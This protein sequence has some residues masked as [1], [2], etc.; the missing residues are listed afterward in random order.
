MSKR[1]VATAAVALLAIAAAG[2]GG[3]S[4]ASSS[5]APATTT[6]AASQAKQLKVGLSL[7]LG[8]LNDRGFNHLS[9]VGLTRAERELGIEGRIHEA[10]S[11]QDYIPNMTS[12]ARQGF[13]LIIAIG[14]DQANAIAA[15]AKK[16]PQTHF[17]IVDVDWSTLPGKPKNVRGLLFREQQVGYLAG[18][19]AGLVVK[20]GIGYA[21]KVPVVSTVGG[22]KQPPVDRYIAGYQ[23][24]ARAAYPGIK[25]LNGYSQDWVAQDKCKE[26]ALNQIA[27]GSQVVFQVAGG[28]GLGA[29]DA[30]KEQGVWGIGVDADQ[31]YLGPQ[32]LTSAT[33][34]VDEAV[35]QTIRDTV[36]GEFTGGN[37][38]YGLDK[39]GVGLGK[40][41]P[42]VPK[43]IVAKVDAI[44]QEIVDGK[45]A[46]IPTTVK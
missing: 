6:A 17:A 42:K 35:F 8:Q 1:L 14:F 44:K 46:D 33:K 31:S 23:A 11:S 2:C 4:S 20:D 39:R 37:R 36:R 29:L 32:V 34:G 25:L 5:S 18:Y 15:V 41:S 38:I 12:F 40:I 3:G 22:E 43:S 45:I 21:K 28:C 24:G 27:A 13:G 7:D 9:Y 26:L 10:A 19:L 30:A 16:F